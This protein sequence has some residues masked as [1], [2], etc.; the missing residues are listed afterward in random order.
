MV[1]DWLP[2]SKVRTPGSFRRMR[3]ES[4]AH[5]KRAS[6]EVLWEVV[7]RPD[8]AEWWRLKSPEMIVG[9]SGKGE[10]RRRLRA[11]FDV[12]LYILIMRNHFRGEPL[13]M[14]SR[15]MMSGWQNMSKRSMYE[16]LG[17]FLVV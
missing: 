9:R 8:H 4:V 12:S 6:P 16:K 3:L 13:G 2:L 10:E 7:S 5:S 14:T 15:A 1:D 17:L 11:L